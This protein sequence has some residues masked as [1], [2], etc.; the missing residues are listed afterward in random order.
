MSKKKAVTG[1]KKPRIK[2]TGT[3]RERYGMRLSKM[4]AA[5]SKLGGPAYATAGTGPHL[6]TAREALDKAVGAVLALP[7]DWQPAHKRKRQ[8]TPEQV[9][10]MKE[11]LAALQA[12]LAE[13][14]A[15]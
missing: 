9:A 8:P 15:A 3:P 11:R 5:L 13:V 14:E 2:I 7:E 6:T 10:R 12:K 1:E 4:A